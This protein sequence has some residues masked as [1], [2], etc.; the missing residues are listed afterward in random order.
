M[1]VVLYH[2]IL[3]N[4]YLRNFDVIILKYVILKNLLN[5]IGNN[6]A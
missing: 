3:I 5:S 4:E 1:I 6:A 2:T